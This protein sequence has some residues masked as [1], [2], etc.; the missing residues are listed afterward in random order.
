M[1]YSKFVLYTRDEQ[2]Q[3][4][5]PMSM[6]VSEPSSELWIHGPEWTNLEIEDRNGPKPRK[7]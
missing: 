7:F 1:G 4:S 5:E 2:T 3:V 6:S